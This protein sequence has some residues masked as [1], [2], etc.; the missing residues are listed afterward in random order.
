MSCMAC[1]AP[2]SLLPTLFL[3]TVSFVVFVVLLYDAGANRGSRWAATLVG[4][5]IF[6]FAVEWLNTQ[7]GGGHIYCYPTVPFFDMFGVPWWVALG[8]GSVIY[9]STWTA[10][11]L[12]LPPLGQAIAA[13]F[14]AVSVDFSLDPVAELFGF[15]DWQCFP[16]SFFDVPYDN[17]IGWYLIV[18]VYALTTPWVLGRLRSSW[19]LPPGQPATTKS[20]VLQ[21]LLPLLCALV[22][23]VVLVA[24]KALLGSFTNLGVDNGKTAAA[25]FVV[26]TLV[27]GFVTFW[28]GARNV[29]LS[30]PPAVNWPVIIA[31]A[32][33][34]V[35]CYVLFLSTGFT[36]SPFSFV[37]WTSESALVASIPIQLLSGL[38]VFTTPWRR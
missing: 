11:R 34:H 10:Q 29:V 12:Q 23:V 8:W 21:W 18:F 36:F 28:L 15:W 1:S 32:V 14:L 13:A 33:I 38:F 22:A 19:F 7:T 4:G 24:V 3:A 5:A 20:F 27:G 37:G 25:I 6:G 31:P 16:V 2:T 17:Y 30:T 35:A 26:L 9:A